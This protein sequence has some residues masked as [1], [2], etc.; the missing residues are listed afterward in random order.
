MLG[1]TVVSGRWYGRAGGAVRLVVEADAHPAR[2]VASAGADAAVGVPVDERPT[3]IGVSASFFTVGQ[4]RLA[5]PLPD[6]LGLAGWW[7]DLPGI[8]YTGK[9]VAPVEWSAG[10][11][12]AA[13]DRM[14]MSLGEHVVQARL[15]SRT[16]LSEQ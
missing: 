16:D 13:L 6:E 14:A 12:V 4:V 7:V 2:C 8:S 15:Y 5:G 11:V 10:K 1:D 9:A 3:L